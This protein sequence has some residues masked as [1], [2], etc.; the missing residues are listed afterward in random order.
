MSRAPSTAASA[1]LP[2]SCERPRRSRSSHVARMRHAMMAHRGHSLRARLPHSNSRVHN[3][4]ALARHLRSPAMVRGGSCQRP[5]VS[6]VRAARSD[7]SVSGARAQ[8]SSTLCDRTTFGTRSPFGST[9]RPAIH[10]SCSRRFVTGRSPRPRYRRAQ[11]TTRCAWPWVGRAW[12]A[13]ESSPSVVGCA[14]SPNAS[15]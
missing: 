8:G 6:D 9:G 13:R 10:C 11:M 5:A 4:P 12:L 14:G 15:L 7:G 3:R 1:L 2:G